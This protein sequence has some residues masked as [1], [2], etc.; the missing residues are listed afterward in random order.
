MQH[1]A[2]TEINRRLFL[3]GAAGLA[4]LPA[5][6]SARQDVLWFAT[7][8]FDIQ[9]TIEYHD[10][11]SSEG[12]WFREECLGGQFCLSAAGE[13]DRRCLADFRGSLAVAQYRF[14]PRTTGRIARWMR[15]SVRTIDRDPRLGDRP[16]FERRI[17]LDRGMAS[18]LQAFGYES[19]A[20]HR[21]S[22]TV[23][24]GPWYL[25]RQDL[26]L[27]PQ[28]QPFLTIYWKHGLPS[29]RALD[30]IPGEQTWPA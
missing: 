19:S 24:R 29:I 26:Y 3:R 2:G 7:V 23:P 21:V 22:P 15:E 25:F 4:A 1:A 16:A 30:I 12:F 13:K 17:Q 28:P 6:A 14:H 18:D 5:A 10:G 9:M 20:G 11:Y 27:E 8:E